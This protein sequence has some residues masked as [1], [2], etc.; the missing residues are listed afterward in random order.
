MRQLD[1]LLTKIASKVLYKMH[2][3]FYVVYFHQKNNHLKLAG[4]LDT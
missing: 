1:D 2:I 4:K 3:D